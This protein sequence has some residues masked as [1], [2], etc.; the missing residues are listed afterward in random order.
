MRTV[1]FLGLI[2][3]GDMVGRLSVLEVETASDSVV[4]LMAW[5]FVIA[6]IMDVVEFFHNLAK[7]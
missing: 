1:I 6:A 4:M 5:I 2:Y 3:V 7:E